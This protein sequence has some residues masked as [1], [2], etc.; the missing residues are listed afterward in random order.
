MVQWLGNGYMVWMQLV[1]YLG[2]R[3][4]LLHFKRGA[5]YAGEEFLLAYL[6]R[7]LL[8]SDDIHWPIDVQAGTTKTNGQSPAETFLSPGTSWLTDPTQGLAIQLPTA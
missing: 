7:H 5:Q 2:C 4:C 8:E 3:L 6:S 1:F